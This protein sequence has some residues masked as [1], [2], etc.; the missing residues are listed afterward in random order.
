MHFGLKIWQLVATI[1]TISLRINWPNL[2]LKM[3]EISMTCNFQGYFSRTFQDQ[4]DFRGLSRS[5]NFTEKKSRTFQEAW[6]PWF[7]QRQ[8]RLCWSPKINFWWSLWQKFLHWRITY[9]WQHENKSAGHQIYTKYQLLC[10]HKAQPISLFITADSALWPDLE[11][12]TCAV[13]P[14]LLMWPDP[15][16][17]AEKLSS[18]HHIELAADCQLYQSEHSQN[19]RYRVNWKRL[20]IQ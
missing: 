15:H 6:E 14:R 2:V 7:F 8:S 9:N 20:P 11:T 19:M 3:R 4:S 12:L 1:L 17:R 10:W 5:W 16:E 13:V 18:D